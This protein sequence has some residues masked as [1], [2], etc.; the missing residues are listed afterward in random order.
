MRTQTRRRAFTLIELLVVIAIIAILAAMLLP[1]LARAKFRAKCTNCQSNYRQWCTVANMYAN[2]N[3][4]SQLPAFPAIG[5]GGWPWDI[6]FQMITNLVPY[7][8]T[9]P[10]WFCPVRANEWAAAQTWAAKGNTTSGTISSLGDLARYLEN[11]GYPG[12]GQLRHSYWV[13]RGGYPTLAD[14]LPGAEANEVGSWPVSTTDKTVSRVP[15]ISDLCKTPDNAAYSTNTAKI[16]ITLAHCFAGSLAN[17]NAAYPD[18]HVEVH[19]K[20]IIKAVYSTSG[21]PPVWFY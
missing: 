20:T 7:N 6:S 18:G 5:Y 19:N 16:D 21:G 12:E 11:P 15:F 10:M 14:T 4:K 3:P 1:A 2:D 8:L 9:V 13:V 17:V